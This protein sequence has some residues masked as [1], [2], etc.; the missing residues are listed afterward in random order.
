VIKARMELEKI[1]EIVLF[2]VLITA[3]VVIILLYLA[4]WSLEFLL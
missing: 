1:V 3:F 4:K 2:A